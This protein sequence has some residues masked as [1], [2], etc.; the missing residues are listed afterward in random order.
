M[1]A[2]QGVFECLKCGTQALE[3]ASGTLC[4]SLTFNEELQLR[5]W[6]TPTPKKNYLLGECSMLCGQ[7]YFFFFPFSSTPF[8]VFMQVAKQKSGSLVTLIIVD[9]E[10]F[11][12][13]TFQHQEIVLLGSF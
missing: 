9:V 6:W 5:P 3:L 12:S 1:Y 2:S 10:R 8:L 13:P 7:Q 11:F 4:D